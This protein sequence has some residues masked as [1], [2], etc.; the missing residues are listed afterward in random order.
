MDVMELI[1]QGEGQHVEFKESFSTENKAIGTLC[2]FANAEGGSVLV[3]V[4][5]A[6]A[7][8][9]VSIGKNTLENF[10][11]KLRDS[12]DP[13]LHPSVN[14]HEV[15]DRTVVVVSVEAH[16]P[17]ELFYAF[18]KPHIRVGKTNQI[19]TSQEQR[20]RLLEGR[21]DW[22]E[23]RDRP[24]FELG[25]RAVTRTEDR[26]EPAWNLLQV[27]GDYVPTIEWRFRGARLRPP[28]EWRQV[29]GARLKGERL[30]DAVCSAI[31]DLSQP[32]GRDERVSEDQIGFEV[33]FHWR[34]R[35]RH[36]IH[37][38]SLT[39]AKHTAKAMWDVGPEILPPLSWD[40]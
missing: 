32:P 3:G 2:A 7:V 36:E 37:R 13:S 29:S 17:G 33:R 21:N 1:K 30:K 28:M 26:F 4:A 31:F 10:A 18:N 22:A 39:R 6:G 27:S 16:R 8:V 23:E 5:D 11:N 25:S 35:L 40:E 12:T 34:G 38:F 15:D 19:M 9:G 20:A 14:K 24:R